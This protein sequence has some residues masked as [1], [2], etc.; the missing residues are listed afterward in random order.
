LPPIPQQTPPL[1]IAARVKQ[2]DFPDRRPAWR[3]FSRGFPHFVANR[4]RGALGL[5]RLRPWTPL[6]HAAEHKRFT[7]QETDHEELRKERK[8]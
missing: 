3:Q 2:E 1:G 7:D 4:V 8:Q 5:R 6:L